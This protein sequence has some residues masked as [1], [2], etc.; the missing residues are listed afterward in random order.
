M[1]LLGR[2]QQVTPGVGGVSSLPSPLGLTYTDPD[3]TVWRWSDMGAQVFVT[4]VAGLGSPP[5]SLTALALPSGGGIP[6]EYQGTFRTVVVGLVIADDD[7]NEF[8]AVMDR[9]NRAL[10][11][12]RAGNPA[13]GTLTVERPDGTSRQILVLTT[14]GPDRPDETRDTAGLTWCSF[15]VTFRA[16]DPLWSDAETTGFEFAAAPAGAGVP[17]MPPV[18]LSPGSVLGA[19]TVH[20]TGDADA[21]PVWT[22]HGPGTPT[23]TNSTTGRSFGLGVALGS[24][25][26]VTVTT[27]TDGSASAVDGTNADRWGDLVK[28]TPRDLWALVPGTNDLNLVLTGSGTGSKISMSY[29][30]RWLAA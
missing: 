24:A 13:P 25:E 18:L 17:P 5:V 30:R 10:W 29:R 3:G 8:L 16:L 23:I 20:N 2:P 4:G 27:G 14:A 9:L 6:Q 28:S 26:V 11:T 7:Q 21:Y 19:T 12:Q 1:P 22:I 15:P